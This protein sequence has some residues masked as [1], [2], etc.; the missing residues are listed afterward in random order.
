[1][2][3]ELVGVEIGSVPAVRELLES[4]SQF[5]LVDSFLA[6]VGGELLQ[7][8]YM[9]NQIMIDGEVYDGTTMAARRVDA[10]NNA[11]IIVSRTDVFVG[12]TFQECSAA[13]VKLIALK[14]NI[15]SEIRSGSIARA[16]E[17]L[18]EFADGLSVILTAYQDGVHLLARVG[19]AN[20]EELDKSV[21]RMRKLHG[22]LKDVLD[23]ID[24]RDFVL[25]SD[26]LEFEFSDQ[27]EEMRKEFASW[28][29]RLSE[30]QVASVLERKEE[31]TAG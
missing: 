21:L 8:G 31:L 23:G 7:G 22:V 15:T 27:L 20:D 19:V 26:A 12:D 17:N 5:G 16:S 11:E 14:E 13:I 3:V 9:V 1:M 2:K 25:I 24:Q 28:S 18:Y 29:A 4:Q 6:A 30:A 10:P